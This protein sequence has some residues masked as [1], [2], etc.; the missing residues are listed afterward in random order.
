MLPPLPAH[1][2]NESSAAHLLNRAGFG[3]PPSEIKKLASL[4]LAGAVNSLVD[5][6]AL[7]DATPDPTWAKPDPD[8]ASKLRAFQKASPE[9]RKEMQK[10]QQRLQRQRMEELRAWW[11]RRMLQGPRPLQEKLTLFW[12]GH[13]ATSAVKVR[14]AY[15]MW[16]QNHLFREL[17]AGPWPSLLLEVSRDPA[18]LLWLDQAQSRREHPNENF[19]RE[20]LELFALGEG[21]YTEKD[22][23]EAA[24]ALTDWG[25]DR[26]QQRFVHKPRQRDA[27]AK[28]MLGETGDLR[29]DDVLRVVARH[30]ASARF[31]SQ[32]LWTFFAGEPPSE[33]L[34][35]S[36]AGSF[37]REGRV[38]RPLLR[39]MFC[40]EAFYAPALIRNQVKSPVQWLVQA[41][42]T[43]EM[44][45]PAPVLTNNA[46]R[47]LGQDLFAPPSVKGWDGELAWIS[48]NSLLN[49][50]QLAAVL[51]LGVSPTLAP[52][53]PRGSLPLRARRRL[54]A[55]RPAALA[56]SALLTREERSDPVR[57]L[58]VLERRLLQGNLRDQHRDAI[59][60]YLEE[61]PQPDDDDIRH[62]V[63][64]IMCTPEYQ[65]T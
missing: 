15:L 21:H 42:R 4:G 16:R 14:D 52:T 24:R 13:F 63:R 44:E 23:A 30:P 57:V 54:D 11:L 6:T 19:A 61:R 53:R 62:V 47:L 35:E 9:A 60:A 59:R 22:I 20:L 40:S 64:L 37:V 34:Q 58:A 55:S 1:R 49:R 41:A 51:V 18:M 46:L 28:T 56:V 45:L 26:V 7:P 48:T 31:L 65:L 36:L 8:R 32:R 25:Y 43:L 3:G 27:G 12:H 39:E 29:G 10:E 17:G 2:W 5:F 33:A 38:I 50:H